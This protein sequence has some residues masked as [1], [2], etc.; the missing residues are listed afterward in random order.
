[1]GIVAALAVVTLIRPSAA[2]SVVV[3]R[4]E[5]FPPGSVTEL[6]YR[7][8][9]DNDGAVPRGS[10][11]E[12]RLERGRSALFLV[13]TPSDGLI[14]LWRRDPHLGCTVGALP[15]AEGVPDMQIAPGTVF[16]NPCHGEQYALDG[17]RLWGPAPRGLDRFGVE[18]REDGAVVVDVTTY[19][20]GR[21]A[22][23]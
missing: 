7:L 12:R 3:G 8:V 1:M 9:G 6:G 22:S 23:P 4:V 20:P 14:V 21:P 10:D 18:V 5:D 16:F 11:E 15:L 13:N 2:S 17:T 19:Q